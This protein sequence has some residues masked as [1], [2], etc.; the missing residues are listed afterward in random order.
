M[1]KYL[2][3]YL[4]LLLLLVGS[5]VG[6]QSQ[7]D[8]GMHHN[9]WLQ[10][11][12]TAK[13]IQHF[14]DSVTL[15]ILKEQLKKGNSTSEQ[16]LLK[17][18]L[19][20]IQLHASLDISKEM[21][22][23]D[24]ER[25]NTFPVPVLLFSDTV[26]Q[27]Y[28]SIGQYSAAQRAKDLTEKLNYL[29]KQYPYQ[30]DSLT[31]QAHAD[32][33][34]IKYKNEVIAGLS[35]TDA[36]WENTSLKILSEKLVQQINIAVAKYQQENNWTNTLKRIGLVV[37]LIV[38]ILLL[39]FITNRIFISSV[40]K[41][42]RSKSK[43]LSEIKIKDYKVFSRPHL[44]SILIQILKVIRIVLVIVYLYIGV[45]VLF[46]IFPATQKWSNNIIFFVEAPLRKILSSMLHYLPNL[47][48]IALIVLVFRLITKILKYF[49]KEIERGQLKIK[50][51]Y[52]EWSRP[53]YNLV[54]MVLCVLVVIL[55][56]PYLPGSGSIAFKG[57]SVFV[58][59]LLSIGS[60]SAIS[61]AVSGVVITYM[62]PFKIGDWVKVGE[63]T[64][65]VIEKNLLVTR[66]RTLQNEDITLPN[67]TILNSQTVNY[68]KPIRDPNT[69]GLV[70]KVDVTLDYQTDWKLVSEL[71]KKA[72]L[73]TEG[74][75]RDPEPF[76]LQQNLND[77]N[78]AYQLNAYTLQPERMFFIHSD[79]LHHIV[80]LFKEADV[81]MISP[82][83]IN[84]KK[85]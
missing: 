44:L 73:L 83:Y 4:L 9:K 8:S 20:S 14:K 56:F 60:S 29:Y 61:N 45:T 81:N 66:I 41:L 18:K 19:D 80:D 25:A 1:F 11:A 64:G 6:A 67:T 55:I 35:A 17:E 32:I 75:L 82:Q 39:I 46:G 15:S 50:G 76:V 43:T 13:D 68:T 69:I 37:V 16:K 38:A 71:L 47:I 36:L 57:I 85:D 33:Y 58:G 52:S 2:K 23:I 21:A 54:R 24:A 48:P 79:L 49:T 34:A 31:I 12:L 62:R 78:V 70:V 28:T 59:I 40:K 63:F 30:P 77:F 26:F 84:I 3:C 7:Q 10:E 22:E 5:F 27:F 51:F 53:T 72:A 42:V 65:H 74:V